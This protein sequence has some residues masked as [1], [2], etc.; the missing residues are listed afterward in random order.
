M[1]S[2]PHREIRGRAFSTFYDPFIID[3]G[4]CEN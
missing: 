1:K 3:E 4:D 2:P